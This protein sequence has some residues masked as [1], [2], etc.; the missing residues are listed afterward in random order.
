MSIVYEFFDCGIIHG[1]LKPKNYVIFKN[2]L[3]DDLI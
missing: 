1:D 2:S 3:Y